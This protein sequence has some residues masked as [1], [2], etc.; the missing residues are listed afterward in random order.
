[1]N[2]VEH[3]LRELFEKKAR[4]ARIG[5]APP[6]AVLKRGRRRQVGTAAIGATTALLVVVVSIAVLRT[7][8]P[9]HG[10]SST[11]AAGPDERTATIQDFTITAPAG[12]TLIDWWP[13]SVTASTIGG[14]NPTGTAA[15]SPA[16]ASITYGDG[17]GPVL[18]LSPGDPG[19]DEPAVCRSDATPGAT[20]A[21]LLIELGSLDPTT[22]G[23]LPPPWPVPIDPDM[24]PTS[25]PCGLGAYAAFSLG[26]QP[27]FA[28]VASGADVPADVHRKLFDAY[29]GMQAID[30]TPALGTFAP[31]YVVA[32]GT[33]DGEAW[34]VEL[35]AALAL[36]PT[37]IATNAPRFVWASLITGSEELRLH[38]PLSATP[39]QPTAAGVGGAFMGPVGSAGVM[40][41]PIAHDAATVRYD[42]PD[43]SQTELPLVDLPASL[44]TAVTDQ[45]GSPPD[46][47]FWGVGDPQG[48]EIVQL[49][50][51]G[52]EL[53]RQRI[54]VLGAALGSTDP[55]ST[56]DQL[57]YDIADGGAISASGT[58]QGTDWKVQV[59]FYEDGVRL[60]IGG[61]PEDLGVM[62][63]DAPLVRPIGSDGYG[64]LVLVLTDLSV[65]RVAIASEGS[66]KGRWMPASTGD[67]A[68]ARLWVVE[69][70]GAGTGSLELNGQPSGSVRWP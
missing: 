54:I 19:L 18:E 8:T 63:L 23:P 41:G 62:Q 31:G 55:S 15:A 16:S 59:L 50:A 10:A 47:M 9:S 12:W 2:D 40:V 49:D 25:G 53:I 4:D 22:R 14:S 61:S 45:G 32:A 42:A 35:G 26:G 39:M 58:F 68:E 69:L 48:G 34:R 60:T 43:G 11:A 7:V 44:V 29:D 3:E 66:W 17:P 28:F 13:A 24:P 67:G 38:I 46:R 57:S 51:D 6:V 27:Y 20:E 56:N 1:M 65:D 37:P 36:S 33:Q 30:T 21:R 5:P 52:N 70:P 64:A